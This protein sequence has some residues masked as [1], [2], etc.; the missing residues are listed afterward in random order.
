MKGAA[1]PGDV[2]LHLNRT[3]EWEGI[4]GEEELLRRAA[5]AALESAPEP[6]RGEVSV[7]CLP[8]DEIASI[9]REYLGR[10]G[11]TDVVAFE[12]GGDELLGD[13]YV[14]P[15]VAERV[16]R[17]EGVE[18]REEIARLVVHGVLHVLG[19]DHPEDES[20]W[21]SPMFRLQERL[22]ARAMEPGGGAPR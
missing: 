18:L 2:V 15:E 14:C 22:V 7:T 17:E 12:L 13:V 9:N 11:P 4:R 16:A 6:A 3:D 19:H 1:G 10:D 8:A 21:D 20:R 5:G